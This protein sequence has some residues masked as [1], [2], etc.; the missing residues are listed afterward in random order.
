MSTN[1]QHLGIKIPDG[2]DPF[3]RT[4][5]VQNWN[6]LDSY[7]GTWICTST[8]RPTWGTSQAGMVI[9]E[10]DTRRHI[11]WNGTAWK[12]ML[13]S[14]AMWYGSLR[15]Y[16]TINRATT[17]TYTVGTFTTHRPGSVMVM[18]GVEAGMPQQTLFEC[19]F[20][21]MI[22]GAEANIDPGYGEYMGTNMSGTWGGELWSVT[23]VSMGVRNIASGSHSMGLRVITSSASSSSS[24]M[25]LSS[26]RTTALFTNAYD[27]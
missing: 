19:N 22:D 17:V 27:T 3:L 7:P 20:R 18:A 6:I 14:P 10:T 15:P 26:I 16:A 13:T 2:S 21:V 8:T 12:E 1:S 24:H 23:N 5:F 9:L 25:R 11:L 4:D